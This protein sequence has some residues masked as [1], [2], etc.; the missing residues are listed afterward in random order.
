MKIA[1]RERDLSDEYLRFAAQVGA[2]GVDL[3]AERHLPGIAETGRIDGAGLSQL[4]GRI[5]GFG[6]EVFRVTPPRPLRFFDG[7]VEGEREVADL[8]RL[9]EALGGVGIPVMSMPVHRQWNR[10]Y[11]GLVKHTH[12]G[13]YR[14]NAFDPDAM[15]RALVD[16]P[17]TWTDAGIEVH[18][19]RCRR[20]YERLVPVAEASGVNLVIH[21]SDPPLPDAEFSPERWFDIVRAV[22]SP[23][24]GLLYCVGTRREARADVPAEI[25]TLGPTGTIL[26]VHFRNVRGHVDEPEGYEEVAIDEGELDMLAVLESLQDIGYEGVLQVDHLP[27]IDG[28]DGR[29]SAAHAVGYIRGLM[30]AARSRA[31][32]AAGRGG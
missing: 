18:L 3:H 30:A 32:V 14:M 20:L 28:D 12:R 24:N 1:I 29:Q 11:R 31:A 9:L 25:R 19:E 17:A 23:R 16:R 8:A 15:R 22:P 13:G 7:D 5:R 2:D 6:L 4:M 21:P 26:H 27:E 10:G